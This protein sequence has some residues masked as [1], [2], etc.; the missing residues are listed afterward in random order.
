[1][2][3]LTSLS[4]QAGSMGEA[5]KPALLAAAGLKSKSYAPSPAGLREDDQV[6]IARRREW[7]RLALQLRMN[8]A[9]RK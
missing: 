2:A 9:S 7:R 5:H 8:E 3:I 4:S 6:G 1:M